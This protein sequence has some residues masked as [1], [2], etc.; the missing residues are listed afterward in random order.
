MSDTGGRQTS[1]NERDESAFSRTLGTLFRAV[2]IGRE[3]ATNWREALRE[4]IAEEDDIAENINP[5][6]R[7]LLLRL[8][9]FSGRTVED[10]MVPRPD[11]VGLDETA[12]LDDVLAAIRA[13]G[14]TRIPVYRGSLD[15]IIG[16]VHMRDVTTY[17]GS[18]R[19]F[20]L[21]DVVRKIL[22]VPSSMPTIQLLAQMRA[23]RTHMAIVVDEYG[24]TDGLVTITDL[25]EEI[26]G[27]IEDEHDEIAPPQMVEQS[28][29][30]VD[31]DA[32][33]SLETLEEK[34][35]IALLGGE[36]DE[37]IETIGGLVTD[38]AGRVPRRG[39]RFTHPSGLIFE[40]LDADPRRV[41]RLRIRRGEPQGL[42]TA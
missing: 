4:V 38:L 15:E 10:A 11:I 7:R 16:M 5:E 14:H 27:S 37:D 34:F 21:K 9:R 35:D 28:D 19:A 17:W 29:G 2:G 30:S 25:V 24:G 6:E 20:L 41:K 23:T 39:E 18:D 31:A 40:V 3:E 26:V 1:E 32:R 22:F 13:H 12:P 8:I 42:T 36:A 33:A